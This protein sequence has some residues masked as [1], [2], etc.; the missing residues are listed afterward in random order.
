MP[1]LKKKILNQF[2]ATFAWLLII[3]LIRW[4][5][6]WDLL[7]LWLGGA[8][9][10]FL[11]DL[12]HLLYAIVIHP[13]EVTSMRVRR[14][15]SQR[16]IKEA[17]LLLSNTAQERLRLPFHSAL[18]QVVLLVFCFF[19]LTSTGSLFGAGLAMAMTLRLVKDEM[20]ALFEGKEEELRRWLFWQVKAKIPLKTQKVFV[21]TMFLLFLA[22]N[23]LLI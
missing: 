22:L 21:F 4:R 14:L 17:I 2:F 1:G 7:G 11:L 18:F 15:L 10:T 19:V 13:Q 20:L 5:W 23:L 16:Q 3:T 6:E 9:G 8:I 12:D